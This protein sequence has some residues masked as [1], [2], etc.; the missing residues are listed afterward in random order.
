MWLSVIRVQVGALSA[1]KRT[2]GS[3]PEVAQLARLVKNPTNSL[4]RPFCLCPH[5]T[6]RH[7]VP[8]GSRVI[9]TM[10]RPPHSLGSLRAGDGRSRCKRTP[11]ARPRRSKNSPRA[12]TT[13]APRRRATTT[14]PPNTA[15]CFLS[16]RAVSDPFTSRPWFTPRPVHAATR[17]TSRPVTSR[18]WF[19]SRHVH[20]AKRFTLRPVHVANRFTVTRFRREVP[21]RR[22]KY[23]FSD[24]NVSASSRRRRF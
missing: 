19:T 11:E 9:V 13:S 10:P 8:R 23:I 18:P 3:D 16:E 5:T 20:V 12:R 15:P 6:A 22:K 14:P 24:T 2:S 7:L 1:K 21:T 4:V 17:F